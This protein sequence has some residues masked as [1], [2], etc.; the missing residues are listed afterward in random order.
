MNAGAPKMFFPPRNRWLRRLIETGREMPRPIRDI[1]LLSLFGSAKLA[2]TGMACVMVF[3]VMAEMLLHNAWSAALLG[4]NMLLTITRLVVMKRIAQA[5]AAGA[6]TPTDAYMWSLSAWCLC[7]GLGAMLAMASN[8]SPLQTVGFIIVVAV[9]GSISVRQYA[10]GGFALLLTCLT[11]LPIMAGVVFASNHW[12]WILL[13]LIPIFIYSNFS[14]VLDLQLVTRD[15]LI[16]QHESHQL[17]RHDSLTGALNRFGLMETLAALRGV[18]ATEFTIFCF[19]LDGFKLVND[20]HGHMAGDALLKSVVQ[21]LRQVVRAE[22]CVARLGGDEFLVLAPRMG[23]CQAEE[24]AVRL[25]SAIIGAPHEMESGPALQIGV[26]I[27]FACA[28][29][30]GTAFPALYH[31]ADAGLYAAKQANRAAAQS[32]AMEVRV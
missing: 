25:R 12:L 15:S 11:T 10:G 5:Q 21:R 31:H 14:M 19:D 16:A 6:P 30:H 32:F 20:T 4:G 28:P 17:A 9:I 24:F 29:L 23:A 2:V 7:Q 13:L 22:D 27:G 3:D 26:S 18:N 1:M 8:I